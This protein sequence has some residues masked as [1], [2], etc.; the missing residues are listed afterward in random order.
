[1]APTLDA[2][3][4]ALDRPERPLFLGREPCLPAVPLLARGDRRWTTADTACAALC[5]VP[6]GG[7]PVR[8]QWPAGQGP[9]SGEGIDRIVDLAD[10]RNWRTGLH[11]G[12][13]RVVEGQ[14]VPT[15]TVA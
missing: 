11:G 14:I 10:L 8:A 1:R 15:A 12:S 13:R 6:G 9:E 3:A 4:D 7:K 2:L 5:T